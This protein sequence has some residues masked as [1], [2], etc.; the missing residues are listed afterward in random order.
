MW[1]TFDGVKRN[2]SCR[3]LCREDELLTFVIC[4]LATMV[5]C[6]AACRNT[7]VLSD[8]NHAARLF[9]HF[10]SWKPSIHGV[11]VCV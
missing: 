8:Y 7:S 5:N 11:C 10:V 3:I 1:A 4:F 9:A 6:V 2:V